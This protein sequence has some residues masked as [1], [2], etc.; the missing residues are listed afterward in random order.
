MKNLFPPLRDSTIRVE[1]GVSD[2]DDE[3]RQE[4]GGKNEE[5][6]KKK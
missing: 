3:S 6:R 1:T 5:R 2:R 4:R